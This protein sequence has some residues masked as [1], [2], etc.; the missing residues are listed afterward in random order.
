MDIGLFVTEYVLKLAG[1][2]IDPSAPGYVAL[3]LM[4]AFLVLALLYSRRVSRQKNALKW[5]TTI[6]S[7]PK[8]A[9]QFTFQIDE[10][11]RAITTGA[12]GRIRL[13]VIDSW[14]QFQETLL[15][16]GDTPNQLL[17]NSVRPSTFINSEDLQM[18][19]GFWRIIPGL[20]VSV[21]L[22][23]TFLGLVAALAQTQ[24]LLSDP[25]QAQ[26]ALKGLVGTASA[27]FI[28]SLTGLACSILFTAHLRA[29]L[30][31]I[32]NA[33]HTL[34][35]SL[36]KRLPYISL[37]EVALAQLSEMKKNHT[38]IQTSF[39]K[40]SADLR[41][42]L[43]RVPLAI[44]EISSP[45]KNEVPKVIAASI[46][47]SL[48]PILN[49]I[50]E[51]STLGVGD[52]VKSLSSQLTGDIGAALTDASLKITDA[53]NALSA[54]AGQ[55]NGN[56]ST[57]TEQLNDT[58][59]RLASTLDGIRE[60]ALA[61]SEN[62][63]SDMQVAGQTA[64]DLISNAGQGIAAKFAETATEV[65]HLSQTL[66]QRMTQDLLAPMSMVCEKLEQMNQE[67]SIG[68][69]DI[70]RLNDGIRLGADQATA[71]AIAFRNASENFQKYAAPV[72]AGADRNEATVA[73]MQSSVAALERA[74]VMALGVAE[75]GLQAINGTLESVST[76]TGDF[77][78][79][80]DRL[81]TMDETLGRAF[82]RY[83]VQVEG[84]LDM[85]RSQIA[86]LRAAMPVQNGKA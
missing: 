53:G 8:T 71:A 68:S 61:S 35:A 15:L 52:L 7:K 22:F 32:E 24:N 28:M 9:A 77:A 75:S 41:Q 4:M 19:A 69:A 42:E 85:L 80:A 84:A 1:L 29:G 27:K 39:E 5:L 17:K 20:F 54:V 6:I 10:L 43:N 58:I 72:T 14:Q 56:S 16:C 12:R 51:M 31:K 64:G 3:S 25:D 45:L 44:A 49:K 50:L 74:V 36:E 55:M 81:D 66:T 46:T 18:D 38:L 34:C 62:A 73:K 79:Q 57:L 76:I 47:T 2:L 65:A 48:E 26:Q 30:S 67:I 63:K 60:A 70:R 83:G 21:G 78:R 59:S 23:L 37:E 40:L 82:E 33:I 11:N 13:Q 86:E